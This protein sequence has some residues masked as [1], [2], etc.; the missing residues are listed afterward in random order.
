MSCIPC[1]AAVYNMCCIYFTTLETF[2]C[3]KELVGIAESWGNAFRGKPDA[4]NYPQGEND[5]P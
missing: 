1:R 5:E 3:L 4:P 2:W